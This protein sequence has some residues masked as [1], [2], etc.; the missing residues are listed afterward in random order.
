MTT[1]A[2]R[3]GSERKA[4]ASE[5]HAAG[6][7][8][9]ASPGPKRR[10]STDVDESELELTSPDRVVKAVL[11]AIQAGRYGPGHRL[12]ETDLTGQ[13]NVSRGSVREAFKRL[14][15][16]GVVVL[17]RNRG[18]CVTALGR[19]EVHDTLV[20]LEALTGLAA[21]LAA[22]HIGED[23]NA[24][25]MRAAAERI[26]TFRLRGDTIA[27]FDE[28]RRFYDTLIQI[29]GN[30]AVGRTLPMIQI[31][32]VR[33]QF[34]SFVMPRDWERQFDDY[35]AISGAVLAGDAR[36]AERLTRI[37]IR[38]TRIHIDRLPD[39]AFGA[40]SIE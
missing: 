30:T 35:R 19:E 40:T 3:N 14:A 25:L 22:K 17:R 38:R 32:L 4:R 16:E 1:A 39:E 7:K 33:M 31:Q 20:V 37:H 5:R 9:L 21:R 8:R 28:R 27:F 36:R 18:A 2:L 15:A 10:D 11:L 34:Q 6:S 24:E 26:A 13:L 29:G 23:K 12:V